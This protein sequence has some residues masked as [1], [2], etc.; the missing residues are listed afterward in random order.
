MVKMARAMSDIDRD[1]E[2]PFGDGMAGKRIVETIENFV[3][4]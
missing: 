3:L 2:N 4:P 1:W